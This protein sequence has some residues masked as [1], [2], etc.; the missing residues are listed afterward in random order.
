M[1]L[2]VNLEAMAVVGGGIGA[3][4][5]NNRSVAEQAPSQ[6]TTT[7]EVRP[8]NPMNPTA[9]TP[10]PSQPPAPAPVNPPAPPVAPVSTPKV[11]PPT[12]PPAPAP[13]PAAA[14]KATTN[15]WLQA[16]NT[17]LGK[18]ISASADLL[19]IWNATANPK[20]TGKP[21]DIFT[22]HARRFWNAV[23]RDHAARLIFALAGSVFP[24]DPRAAPYFT[25]TGRG[26]TGTVSIDHIVPL[27]RDGSPTDPNNLRFLVT[28]DNTSIHNIN[29]HAIRIQE[30]TET[31][32]WEENTR[33]GDVEN[34]I[35]Q[36]EEQ[37]KK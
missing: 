27:K 15:P 21:R 19:R 24:K 17:V 18:N 34:T 9:E 11:A 33:L 35:R 6:R 36:W 22:A 5:A 30:K 12:L 20:A 7:A 25:V 23:N 16:A 10:P 8:A 29:K 28:G 4:R 2:G 3:G 13:K 31:K 26:V 37:N 32:G 14:P 1:G